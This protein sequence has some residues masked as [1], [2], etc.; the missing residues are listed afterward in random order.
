MAMTLGGLVRG[1]RNV[2]TRRRTLFAAAE[3]WRRRSLFILGGIGVGCLAVLLAL[4]ADRAQSTFVSLTHGQT[5]IPWLLTPLGFVACTFAARRWFQN[6]QGSGIPQTI[7][8]LREHDPG[9]RDRLVSLRVASGK[10]ILTVAGL[11]CGASTGREGPTVQ[12]GAS[13]LYSAGRYAPRLRG[14]LIVAGGAAGIAAA[15][16]APLAGIMF[17]IEEMSRRF[18]G[19]TSA[20]VSAAQRVPVAVARRRGFDVE[21]VGVAPRGSSRQPS[22]FH[23]VVR[24]GDEI[25]KRDVAADESSRRS[26]DGLPVVCRVILLDRHDVECGTCGRLR[27]HHCIPRRGRRGCADRHGRRNR[28]ECR[29]RERAAAPAPQRPANPVAHDGVD[30]RGQRGVGDARKSPER[31]PAEPL[32]HFQ[33]AF[34]VDLWSRAR[35]RDS[36]ITGPLAFMDQSCANPP[37]QRVKPEH[38]LDDEMDAGGQIVR[39]IDMGHLMADNGVHFC[40]LEF[41]F[42][43]RRPQQDRPPN[44]EDRRRRHVRRFDDS[45]TRAVCEG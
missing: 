29:C 38:R 27:R 7:V 39:A 18:D 28:E 15:F 44:S 45:H 12:V 37:D 24:G 22:G 3:R 23:H 13:I 34:D 8:A 25:Q 43:A 5:W 32:A 30:A 41:A 17:G 42:E 26:A 6:S 40:R 11:L 20:L 36:L 9:I 16:N 4:L 19:P 10:L 2:R 35:E 33:D 1:L 21:L 31:A 14:G